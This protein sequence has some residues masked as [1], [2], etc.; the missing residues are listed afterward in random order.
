MSGRKCHCT[1]NYIDSMVWKAYVGVDNEA[2]VDSAKAY[3]TK[4]K[5]LKY[6]MPL[7]NMFYQPMLELIRYLKEKQFTVYIVSGSIQGVIWSVCPGIIGTDRS[8]LIGTNQL[9]TPVYKTGDKKTMLVINKGIYQPK[10]D[11]DGKSLNIYSH[12]GKV[13]VF[14]FGNTTGDFGMFHLTSTSKYP[15]AVYLLN[16][17]DGMREYEYQPWHGKACPAWKDTLKLNHWNLVNMAGEFKT[18]WMVNRK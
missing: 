13:P 17:D 16:H 12:I 8:H 11:G 5:C 4:T 2:Y 6:K 15:H 1:F 18:V 14:A 10:D 9:L 3:L 7:A